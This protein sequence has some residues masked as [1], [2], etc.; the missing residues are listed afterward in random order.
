MVQCDDVG[1]LMSTYEEGLEGTDVVLDVV[2]PIGTPRQLELVQ[3]SPV[4]DPRFTVQFTNKTSSGHRV[5]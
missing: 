4:R 2:T 5:V 3:K 1:V